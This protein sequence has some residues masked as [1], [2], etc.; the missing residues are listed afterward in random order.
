MG[1]FLSYLLG[2]D[3]G[4]PQ[5]ELPAKWDEPE[6]A[7]GLTPRQKRAVVDTWALV[8]PDLKA[9]G[10]AVLIALFEAHPEHQRLFSAFRDVPLSE[11]R[12]SKRFA[13]HA[14]SVMHAIASLVDTLE[15]DTEVLVEL[16]TKIGVNHAKHSVPPHAF[17]VHAAAK[18]LRN[19][20]N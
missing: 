6:P 12:G 11:L 9:T 17:S 7:T 3:G 8:Q 5:E 18:T 2:S 1:G 13:A 14:S 4:A 20:T 19:A 16:L 10:I 15:D